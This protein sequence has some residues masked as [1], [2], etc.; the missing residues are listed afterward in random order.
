MPLIERRKGNRYYL[1]RLPLTC[2]G[3]KAQTDPLTH[4]LPGWDQDVPVAANAGLHNVYSALCGQGGGGRA[5]WRQRILQENETFWKVVLPL[6][7]CAAG[8][9]VYSE[10]L[11]EYERWL[12]DQSRAKRV[13]DRDR[14]IWKRMLQRI[15]GLAG[16]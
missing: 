15:R 5:A 16:Q 13:T 4:G 12:S 7:N 2:E 14:E 9:P 3:G 10:V 6:V 1:T 8:T 11:K